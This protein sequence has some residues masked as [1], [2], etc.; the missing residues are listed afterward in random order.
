MRENVTVIRDNK[1]VAVYAQLQA[2][3]STLSWRSAHR[4]GPP[5]G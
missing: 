4:A 2:D 5:P 1:S 3:T